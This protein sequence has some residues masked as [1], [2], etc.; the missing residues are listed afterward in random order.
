MNDALLLREALTESVKPEMRDKLFKN[1]NEHQNNNTLLLK[2]TMGESVRPEM[3][4]KMLENNQNTHKYFPE[5]RP[6]DNPLSM[7]ASNISN[8]PFRPDN[9]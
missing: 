5:Y 9:S 2:E 4:S 3:R 8:I 1:N 6:D 7:I